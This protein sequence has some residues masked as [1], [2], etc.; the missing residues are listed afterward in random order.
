MTGDSSTGPTIH[1]SAFWG[2]LIAPLM[3]WTAAVLFITAAGQPGV[4]CMTPM[5][6]LL[7]LWSGVRYARWSNGQPDR[8][9]AVL[10]G[11]V[12]GLGLGVIFVLVSTVAMPVA[13]NEVSKTIV[14]DAI[15]IGAGM[16]ICAGLCTFTARSTWRRMNATLA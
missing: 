1:V 10:L 13:P 2:A 9:G 12:L 5:A 14:L 8:F 4:V 7:A 11:A 15:M 16:V 6:W 3:A